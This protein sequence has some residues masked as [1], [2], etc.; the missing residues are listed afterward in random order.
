MSIDWKTVKDYEREFDEM[1]K[2]G[3]S[4][5]MLRRLQTMVLG[6]GKVMLRIPYE[7]ERRGKGSDKTEVRGREVG[8]D[9]KKYVEKVRKEGGAENMWEMVVLR[10]GLDGSV[11]SKKMERVDGEEKEDFERCGGGDDRVS[12]GETHSG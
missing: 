5:E 8:G 7:I 12:E 4:G 9:N 2:N 6:V 1:C 11:Y 10:V 3:Y